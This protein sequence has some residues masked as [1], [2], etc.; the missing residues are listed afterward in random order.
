MASTILVKDAMW[1]I[2]VI[3][4]DVTPQFTFWPEHELVQ[5]MNDA[6]AAI[7]KYLPSACARID[8][9]KLKA[10]TRQS[11]EKIVAT[12]CKPGDGTT[13]T[14]PIYGKMIVDGGMRNMGADGATP[15]SVIRLVDREVKDS[16]SPDWHTVVGTGKVQSLIYNPETPRYFYVYPG[17]SPTVVTWIELP[18]TA[19][20]LQIDNSGTAGSERYLNS[21]TAADLITID[22]EFLEDIVNYVV[23]RAHMKSA[24]YGDPSKAVAYTSMFTGSLNAK[25]AAVTGNSPKLT[26]LPLAG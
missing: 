18:Y 14:L 26:M 25:V 12:D 2:S 21:G 7:T 24:K 1:R 19:Q 13:P 5:W 15:G 8:A 16:Q 17:V 10:G 23:A 6:Q 9:I 3:L 22:D 11:I 4:Q 20:P